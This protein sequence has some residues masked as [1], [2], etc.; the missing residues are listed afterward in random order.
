MSFYLF[1]LRGLVSMAK[2]LDKAI[3]SNLTRFWHQVARLAGGTVLAQGLV[4]VSTPILTRLY[5]PDDFGLL[6]AYISVTA[7]I[8]VVASWR[9]EFTITLPKNDEDAAYLFVLSWCALAITTTVLSVFIF[10]PTPILYNYFNMGSLHS[11]LYFIPI[12]V[13]GGGGYNILT[14]MA[15]RKNQY[16]SIA[17]TKFS[18][19]IGQV[20][21]QIISGVLALGASGLLLG[22]VVG[23]SGGIF[24]LYSKVWRK[25]RFYL[26]TISLKK[27]KALALRYWR[28]PLISTPS[29]LINSLGLN[30]P[31]LLLLT[32][33]G[34]QVVGW[35]ALGQR[36][37]NIPLSLVGRAVSQ[38]F[39]GEA[40]TIVQQGHEQLKKFYLKT[41]LKLLLVGIVPIGSISLFGPKLFAVIF[42][43]SWEQAGVYIQLLFFASIAKFVVNPLSQTL[44]VLERQVIQLVW[45]IIR[46]VLVL[47]SFVLPVFL[48]LPAT[49]AI[50]L[51]SVSSFLAYIVLF[52]ISINELKKVED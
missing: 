4:I 48:N 17:I 3:A 16:S 51:Y 34:P 18:R 35:F 15:V 22:D 7:I 29:S 32:F 5:T 8:T 9:Y 45:D 10:I 39:L 47:I 43:G 40:S 42:G 12:G 31:A 27:L 46:L 28:F 36:V 23:K 14:F 41:G 33:Y 2:K 30:L 37:M 26:S 49:Y 21:T 11:Y 13:I 24:A 19:S 20:T 44:I 38:V 25:E 1:S 6:Q 52:F 50:G